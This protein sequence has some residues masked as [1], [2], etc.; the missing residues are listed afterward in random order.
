MV[1]G[2]IKEA[3]GFRQFLLRGMAKV[4]GE[5]AMICTVHNIRKLAA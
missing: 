5:S 3:G 1:F 4:K 2:R